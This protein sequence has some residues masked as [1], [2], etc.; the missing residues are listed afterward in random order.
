MSWNDKIKNSIF[1]IITGDGEKFTPLWRPA[2]KSFDF[3]TSEFNFINRPGTLVDRKE[4]AGAKIPLVFQFQ[5]ADVLDQAAKFE[6]SSKDK[7]YWIVNHP[8]YG[9]INGQPTSLS[10]SDVNYG[11][12]I[13]SIEFWESIIDISPVKA[14][15][16]V[17]AITL[18]SAKI[19][20][21]SA[22]IYASKAVPK[23]ADISTIKND[24]EV[25]TS[26]TD[27][28]ARLQEVSE[29]QYTEYLSTRNEAF[30]NLDSLLESPIDT[31][32]SINDFITAPSNFLV[33]IETRLSLY[34]AIFQQLKEVLLINDN[35]S[36]KAYFESVGAAV[37]G[38]V[39][40]ALVNPIAGDY[41][42]R[43]NTLSAAIRLQVLFFNYLLALDNAQV[44]FESIDNS[45]FATGDL[46]NTIQNM[47]SETLGNLFFVAF[48]AMQERIVYTDKDSNLIKLTHKYIG[49]DAE[50]KNIET[51][52]Q[53]NNIKNKNLFIVK[54][55]TKITY[56][57]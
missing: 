41:I 37:L 29:Q 2:E 53:I 16:T 14:K 12:V 5:G 28:V 32:V 6:E 18:N 36:N 11:S 55:D 24:V 13:F 48:Q 39:C 17:E 9:T 21:T 20:T 50:D 30:G 26:F 10:R 15:S 23:P 38:G 56:L 22:I 8:Y 43:N 1:S 25:N 46:Q 57:V 51:F 33:S 7:R 4:V 27:K 40:V 44:G 47:V 34:E 35:K 52:R 19:N 49:L 54:K 42:T 45:F 31:I 3:N